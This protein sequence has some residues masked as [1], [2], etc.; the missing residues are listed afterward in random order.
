MGDY[1]E[2]LKKFVERYDGDGIDD[3]PGLRYPVKYWEIVNEPGLQGDELKF[4]HGTSQEYLEILKT[5]YEVIKEV[6]EDAKIVMGG[7]A[8]MH[9]KFVEFWSPI[10][11][12]AGN[13]FDIANIHSIDSDERRKISL[14]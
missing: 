2:F 9:T 12:E 10:I 6:D 8:G 11:K 1:R 5:S 13:Y 4:F 14:F 7:M 3:M